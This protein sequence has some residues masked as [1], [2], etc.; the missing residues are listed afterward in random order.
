MFHNLF[1]ENRGLYAI[2]EII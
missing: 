1:Y 2:Y